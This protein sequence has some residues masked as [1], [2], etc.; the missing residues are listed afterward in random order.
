MRRTFGAIGLAAAG[1]LALGP[2]AAQATPGE[3]D[4]LAERNI[5]IIGSHA[6]AQAGLELAAVGDVNGDGVDEI[7]VIT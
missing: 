4:L 2:A 6:G 1:A 7:A 5:R 3:V